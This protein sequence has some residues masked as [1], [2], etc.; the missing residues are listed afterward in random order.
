MRLGVNLN[1]AL[2]SAYQKVGPFASTVGYVHVLGHDVVSD[3]S[4]Q[5]GDGIEKAKQVRHEQRFVL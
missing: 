1:E 4:I 2:L 5:E 3:L